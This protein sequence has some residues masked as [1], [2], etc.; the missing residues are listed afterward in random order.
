MEVKDGKECVSVEMDEYLETYD[1]SYDRRNIELNKITYS[2][3]RKR[4]ES[5]KK[6]TTCNFK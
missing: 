6:L 4:K 5:E 1:N 3:E 2:K